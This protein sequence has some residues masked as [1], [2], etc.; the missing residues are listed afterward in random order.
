MTFCYPLTKKGKAKKQN[1]IFPVVSTHISK[2]GWENQERDWEASS[3][4]EASVMETPGRW[5]CQKC[6]VCWE[7]QQERNIASP[8]SPPPQEKYCKTGEMANWLKVLV[9]H[10]WEWEGWDSVTAALRGM[11]T[12][13]CWDLLVT[14]P[15]KKLW[16]LGSGRDPVLNE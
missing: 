9:I 3:D 14:G 7:K 2:E 10:A 6:S 1:P 11:E 13:G 15:N 4:F 12:G 5:R 16:A 8:I